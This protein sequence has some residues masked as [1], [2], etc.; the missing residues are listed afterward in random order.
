MK[1][2]KKKIKKIRCA[3]SSQSS[4]IVEDNPIYVWLIMGFYGRGGC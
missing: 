4:L 3:E 2:K 1:N